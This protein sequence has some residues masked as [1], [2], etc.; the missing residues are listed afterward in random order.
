MAIKRGIVSALAVG[1]CASA[2]GAGAVRADDTTSGGFEVAQGTATPKND[3]AETKP[4]PKPN[5]IEEITVRARKVEEKEQSTPVAVTPFSQASME[6]EVTFNMSDL[7]G[8]PNVLLNSLGAFNATAFSIRGGS[9]QD[10]ESSFEPA[11]GVVQDGIYIGRNATSFTNLYDTESV[12]VLRGPQGV[13][14]GRN[15]T[16][17]MVVTRSRRPSGDFGTRGTVSL[18]DRGFQ[19]YRFSLDVPIVPEKVA[20][21][22]AFFQQ[23]SNGHFNN[24]SGSDLANVKLWSMRGILEFT[25]TDA[26]DLTVIWDNFADRSGGA[27]LNP[28]S[29]PGSLFA[30]FGF[31]S[32]GGSLFRVDQQMHERNITQY[33]DLIFDMNYDVGGFTFTSLT[34]WRSTEE[35]IWTDFDSEPLV[36]FEAKRPQSA[37]QFSQ[38]LR[39]AGDLVE[40]VLNFTAG[41]YYYDSH[42]SIE[43]ETAFDVCIFVTGCPSG[44]P[45]VASFTTTS[46]AHQSMYSNGY[47]GQLIWTVLPVMH[48]YAGGRWTIDDKYFNVTP[49]LGGPEAIDNDRW[50]KF[51]PKVGVDLQITPDIFTYAQYSTGF[52]SGGF[53]GRAGTTLPSSV[54]PYDSETRGSLES[55][56]KSE[57]L[58]DRLRVNLTGF[59]DRFRGMQ[60]PVIVPAPAPV[61]QETL[62]QNAGTAQIW[63]LELETIAKPLEPLTVWASAGYLNAKYLEFDADLNGDF[64]VTDNTDLD[65]IRA[66]KY[67]AHLEA[68]YEFM[69]DD[70][71]ALEVDAAGTYVAHYATTA[72]NNAIANVPGTVIYDGSVTYRP[73]DSAWRFTVYGKNLFNRTAVGGGLDVANLF[74]F[75]GPL[76]PRTYGVQIGWQY[77]D[78]GDLIK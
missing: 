56:V 46:Q 43:Q 8:T 66:P 30:A 67:Y 34:G 64:I 13:L 48:V 45:G 31:V 18:G 59:Y 24:S 54:G 25:P 78:L 16:S 52:R 57:W 4:A 74:A 23:Q 38:E 39:V 40:D 72:A 6:R 47:F 71:G 68:M 41:W 62:T 12:E 37:G 21:N 20:A 10:I 49:Q 26:F 22:V 27:P 58:D 70:F 69:I 11:V 35:D 75:N 65:L 19:D 33:S 5:A 7:E 32:D 73:L 76:P 15:S 3:G 29:R 1:L 36:L 28:A 61:F 50:H 53:N 51:T 17:G 2:F 60:L 44:A 9:F 42:Y 63:G 77:D 14:F 55:G